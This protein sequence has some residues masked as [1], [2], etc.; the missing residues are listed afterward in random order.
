MKTLIK[1]LRFKVMIFPDNSFFDVKDMI[2]GAAALILFTIL[3]T[4]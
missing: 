4:N 3:K 1:V 2:I